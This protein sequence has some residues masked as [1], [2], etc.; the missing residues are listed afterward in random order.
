MPKGLPCVSSCEGD[1]KKGTDGKWVPPSVLC[2][3]HIGRHAKVLQARDA[4]VLVGELRAPVFSKV[5]KI[6]AVPA[7]VTLVV[8]EAD[9]EA[10]ARKAGA[11]VMVITRKQE[12]QGLIYDGSQP[13]V[14]N[15]RRFFPPP[16]G[17]WFVVPGTG[18][19][20]FAWASAPGVTHRIRKMMRKVNKRKRLFFH[21][22][23]RVARAARGARSAPEGRREAPRSGAG[24]RAAA[25]SAAAG[26]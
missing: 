22:G 1:V 20:V 12:M 8:E 6:G 2:P 24:C 7:G 9:K 11:L 5:A 15:K 10:V 26:G 21:F 18:Y 23:K 19:A 13:F 16:R 3:V 17:V 14:L 4:G 25:Q